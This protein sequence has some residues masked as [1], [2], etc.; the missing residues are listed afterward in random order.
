MDR[1]KV[2]VMLKNLFE[3]A[4]GDTSTDGEIENALVAASNLMSAYQIER[5]DIVDTDDGLELNITYGKAR[6]YSMYTSIRAWESYL[7]HFIDDFVPGV[8][9]YI[10][11]KRLRRNKAGMAIGGKATLIIF[12][13][14]ELDVQFALEVFEEVRTFIQAAATLRYGKAL[15]QG[16]A[17]AYAEGFA[18]VLYHANVKQQQQLSKQAT[19]DSTALVV[20]S[21]ALAIKEGAE[22]WLR[23]QG[24]DLGKDKGTTSAAYRDFGAY[25]QGQKDGKNYEPTSTKKAGLLI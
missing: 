12:Y 4:E 20:V 10:Q 18:A 3:V 16:Q 17:A 19:S 14:P 7:C 1:E 6:T 5:D 22:N 8:D 2:K 15:A 23:E 13:G 24:T 9:H 21:R 25:E 11:R